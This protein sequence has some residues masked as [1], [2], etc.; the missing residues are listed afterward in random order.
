M[1]GNAEQKENDPGSNPNIENTELKNDEQLQHT[2]AEE[3]SEEGKSTNADYCKNKADT[4]A[5]EAEEVVA[6]EQSGQESEKALGEQATEGISAETE[7][8]NPA[9]SEPGEGAGDE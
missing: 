4:A 1:D 2:P 5:D 3:P 6:V 7:G 8:G 9:A